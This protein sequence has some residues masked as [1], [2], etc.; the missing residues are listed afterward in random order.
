M[1]FLSLCALLL[2]A[3]AAHAQQVVR[4][5]WKH[6]APATIDAYL[7]YEQ[8]PGTNYWSHVLTVVRPNSGTWTGLFGVLDNVPPGNHTYRVT[9]KTV[10]GG[11]S[12]PSK[13][14]K[15]RV[16]RTTQIFFR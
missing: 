3:P 1:R 12:R 11:E 15:V 13:S 8:V 7:I 10:S 14:V 4:L 5:A 9:A 16:R 6:R 2:L